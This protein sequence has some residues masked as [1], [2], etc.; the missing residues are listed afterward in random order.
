[1]RA[2]SMAGLP[3]ETRK[4]EQARRMLEQLVEQV[5]AFGIQQIPGG[6]NQGMFG[7]PTSLSTT[8]YMVCFGLT[9]FPNILQAYNSG[10]AQ[11]TGQVTGGGTGT[12]QTSNDWT[13]P[14]TTVTSIL[15]DV[16]KLQKEVVIGSQGVHTPD[17][18]LLGTKTWSTL[19]TTARSPTFTDDSVIQYIMKQSP[20]LKRVIYWPVLDTAGLKQDNS[21]HGE[22]VMVLESKPENMQLVIPQEFEQLPPQ[23][24]N[25]SFKIPCHMRIGGVTVR[26]PFSI[27]WLDGAAG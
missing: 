15:A 24:V 23:M 1:M 6:G 25:M 14:S 10:T 19:S 3:L 2:A 12:G 20:W 21:T 11:Y 22:R 13:S 27:A 9:N 26:Y 4:A 18:L 7:V 8:D 17:T 5:A 16:N